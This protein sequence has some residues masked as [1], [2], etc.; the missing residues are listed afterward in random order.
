MAEPKMVII[1]I[2]PDSLEETKTKRKGFTVKEEEEEET[3]VRAV[4]CLNSRHDMKRYEETEDCFILDFDPFEALEVRKLSFSDDRPDNQD[5]DDLTI[6]HE[7]GQVACRDYPHPRH[8]CVKFPFG[9]T[10]HSTHCPLCYC[11]VCDSAAPCESWNGMTPHCDAS[12]HNHE[13]RLIRETRN[14]ATCN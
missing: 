4:F 12:E 1:E 11:Y 9:T 2:S 7:K 8:L 3:P 5:D 14:S 6:I 10:P 13:W